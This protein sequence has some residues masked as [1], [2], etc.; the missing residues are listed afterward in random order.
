MGKTGVEENWE[1]PMPS[2]LFSASDVIAFKSID[3]GGQSA[4]NG[5]N[6]YNFGAISNAPSISF[7]PYNKADGADVHVSTGDHVHQSA[8]WAAGGANG[9]FPVWGNANGGT[10]M[11]NGS[12][13]STS[14]QDSSMVS[15][16]TTANQTNSLVADMHQSAGAGI[17]GNGG[18][19][20]M[21]KG[22]DVSF[23][24]V[25]SDPTTETA[26][27][28]NVLNGSDFFHLDDFVHV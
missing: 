25:H 17:G 18:S 1:A 13:N 3:T 11:S 2:G 23:A 7:N 26:S 16:N 14:G 19:G 28:N 24:L 4:G 9:G 20:N 10:A 6:G 15:A 21:A 8:D 22:G 27:L 5:G 12:Q